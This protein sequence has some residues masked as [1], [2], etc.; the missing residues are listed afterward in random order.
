LP[1][2]AARSAFISERDGARETC[3]SPSDFSGFLAPL[4]GSEQRDARAALVPTHP[5]SADGARA[6]VARVGGPPAA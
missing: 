6:T 3:P 5:G 4:L 1:T 2:Q